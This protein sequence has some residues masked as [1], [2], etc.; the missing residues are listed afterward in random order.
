METNW[1]IARDRK[2]LGPFSLAQMQ[3]MVGDGQLLP[4]DMVLQ[5][6]TQRWQPIHA[7]V[8]TQQLERRR[9]GA[10]QNANAG[11][12]HDDRENAQQH[13]GVRS[14]RDPRADRRADERARDDGPRERDVDLRRRA[15]ADERGDRAEHPD[16][17]ACADRDAG[18]DAQEIDERSKDERDRA[19]ADKTKAE[20]EMPSAVRRPRV[21]H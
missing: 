17:E 9:E 5:E 14:H 18:R 3:K 8:R 19:N 21:R 12:D 4:I 1:Y 15:L 13:R 2:K 6:G 7:F 16:A 11:E 20:I 10:E